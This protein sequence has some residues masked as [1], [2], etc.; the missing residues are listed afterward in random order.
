MCWCSVWGQQCATLWFQ[1]WLR[2]ATGQQYLGPPPSPTQLFSLGLTTPACCQLGSPVLP[3]HGNN[4]HSS[5]AQLC[6]AAPPPSPHASGAHPP[7][8]FYSLPLLLPLVF[9]S[10]PPAPLS[11]RCSLGTVGSSKHHPNVRECIRYAHTHMDTHT[12]TYFT[13]VPNLMP[14]VF[15]SKNQRVLTAAYIC[16]ERFYLLFLPLR[17]V[18]KNPRLD[19]FLCVY[20]SHSK[21]TGCGLN[22]S[23]LAEPSGSVTTPASVSNRGLCLSCCSLTYGVVQ[24]M[25]LPACL[26]ACSPTR[27]DMGRESPPTAVGTRSREKLVWGA[28]WWWDL[29]C[30]GRGR[31][32]GTCMDKVGRSERNGGKKWS[33]GVSSLH[34]TVT[35]RLSGCPQQPDMMS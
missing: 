26:A 10:S 25:A 6:S 21:K 3:T 8:L 14:L 20:D 13:S 24:T 22:C 11:H 15:F 34:S 33:E 1:L 18:L 29:S 31:D 5:S 12:H 17:H 16:V 9:S 27:G 28:P 2:F 30:A 7:S 19:C 35:S 23:Q 32:R 4:L